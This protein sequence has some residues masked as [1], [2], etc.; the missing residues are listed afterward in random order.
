MSERRFLFLQGP[1]G[2]FFAELAAKLAEAG[3]AVEKIGFNAGDAH[4]WRD[5]GSYLPF[6]GNP[7]EWRNFIGAYLDRTGTTD[8][9]IYGDIRDIHVIAREEA[10]LRGLSIH[11]FEEGYL[12]PYWVTYERGG[13]NGHSRLIQMSVSQMQTALAGHYRDL[14]QAPAQWGALWHHVL[15]GAVYHAFVY[16]GKR[17]YPAYNPHRSI[18]IFREFMLH[19]RR[20]FLFPVHIIQRVF[21]TRRLK[22]SGAPYHLVMLQLAHDASFLKHSHLSMEGFIE[23]CCRDFAKGARGHHH[24]AFKTHPLEDER[25]GTTALVRKYIRKYRL[26]GRCH[27][28][29]GG[30]LGPLLNFATSVVTVNSTAGQQAL[31]RGLPLRIFGDAVYAKP[32]FISRQPLDV[33]F[34]EPQAPDRDTY[35]EYRQFLLETSQIPGGFYTAG[36]RARVLRLI[37]DV[38]LADEDPYERRYSERAVYRPHL[39]LVP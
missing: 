8:L 20:V 9:V 3:C 21:A 37:S 2:P 35:R 12:R 29:P 26:R 1:H 33:F 39:R 7:Q 16:F 32:E 19:L 17:L 23:T 10:R 28:I 24:L 6:K 30:K 14:P 4:F 31:W 38:I 15:L 27:I 13:V 18:S 34:A 5:R 11:C 36:G 22:R 25:C